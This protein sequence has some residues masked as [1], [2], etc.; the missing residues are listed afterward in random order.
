MRPAS[1]AGADVALSFRSTADSLE[2]R[3][4][5]V[6]VSFRRDGAPPG[7]ARHIGSLLGLRLALARRRAWAAP[8]PQPFPALEASIEAR[9][10]PAEMQRRQ[11]RARE[12]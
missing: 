6:I 12:P 9:P 4:A 2:A 11:R 7:A 8:P 10:A 5:S 1:P 3:V